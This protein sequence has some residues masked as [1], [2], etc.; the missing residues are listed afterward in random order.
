MYMLRDGGVEDMIFS[1][2][3]STS[4]FCE[5]PVCVCLPEGILIRCVADQGNYGYRDFHD[6][7]GRI[8]QP[9]PL[10]KQLVGAKLKGQR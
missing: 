9:Q 5:S 2:G 4:R 7:S 1:N 8:G 3:D 6:S 10:T